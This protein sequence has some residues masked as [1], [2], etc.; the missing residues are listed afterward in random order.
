VIDDES[1][2]PS[3]IVRVVYEDLPDLIEREARV[4][5]GDW[6]GI[7]RYPNRRHQG[8]GSGP[9]FASSEER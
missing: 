2:L 9:A 3:L 4:G 1:R 8:A 6:S 7:Q 5:S